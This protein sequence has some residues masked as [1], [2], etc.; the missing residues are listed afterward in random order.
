MVKITA[1]MPLPAPAQDSVYS[2]QRGD[3]VDSVGDWSSLPD[4]NISAVDS[5]EYSYHPSNYT[6]S[7]R[8][9][10]IPSVQEEANEYEARSAQYNSDYA[11]VPGEIRLPTHQA[12]YQFPNRI[13]VSTE[14]AFGKRSRTD[15]SVAGVSVSTDEL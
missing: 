3:P 8:G 7:R 1:T 6:S 14:R 11:S 5:A 4:M 2:Q 10:E 12:Q 15:M 13:P 9:G